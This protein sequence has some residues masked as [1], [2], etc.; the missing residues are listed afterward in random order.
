MAPNIVFW[1]YIGSLVDPVRDSL[2]I[3]YR[4]NARDSIGA[5]VTRYI[6]EIVAR[7]IGARCDDSHERSGLRQENTGELATH[8]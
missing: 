7:W 6:W 4:R 8:R 2:T 3:G 1:N 5:T